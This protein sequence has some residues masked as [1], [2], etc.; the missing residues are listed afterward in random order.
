MPNQG[1][2]QS[3]VRPDAYSRT[4]GSYSGSGFTYLNLYFQRQESPVME[5]VAPF[6]H[7]QLMWAEN[8]R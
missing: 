4:A 1:A 3:P 6:F 2:V 8:A 5:A 7:F